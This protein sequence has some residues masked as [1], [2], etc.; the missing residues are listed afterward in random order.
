MRTVLILTVAAGVLAGCR[1]SDAAKSQTT[2]VGPSNAG[3]RASASYTNY[4]REKLMTTRDGQIFGNW[5][6]TFAG[7]CEFGYT[8]RAIMEGAIISKK[9]AGRC[10]NG[11]VVIVV[12]NN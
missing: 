6:P 4:A 9:E 3:A 5:S 7:A 2:R 1:Q 12:E 11:D 8:N 10:P